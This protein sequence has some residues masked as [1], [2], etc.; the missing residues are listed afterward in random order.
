L[1]LLILDRL[2]G[3]DGTVVSATDGATFI[4]EKEED[5]SECFLL[6]CVVAFTSEEGNVDHVRVF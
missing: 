6:L 5:P 3:A 1:T 2:G 4:D